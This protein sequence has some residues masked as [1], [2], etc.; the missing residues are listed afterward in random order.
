[1]VQHLASTKGK[2][3]VCIRDGAIKYRRKKRNFVRNLPTL[4]TTVTFTV[5]IPYIQ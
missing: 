5:V 2:V 4:T 1:M 3:P